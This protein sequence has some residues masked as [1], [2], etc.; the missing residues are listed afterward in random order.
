M[1]GNTIVKFMTRLRR[2]KELSTILYDLLSID[3]YALFMPNTSLQ[4]TRQPQICAPPLSYIRTSCYFFCFFFFELLNET[5]YGYM[6][7]IYIKKIFGCCMCEH[8][9]RLLYGC[10]LYFHI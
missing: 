2:G 10:K 5:Q 3:N 1:L 4:S 6:I 9:F 8:G 7:R